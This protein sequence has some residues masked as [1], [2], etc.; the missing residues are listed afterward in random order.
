M[1]YS[2]RMQSRLPARLVDSP[3][4]SPVAGGVMGQFASQLQS[5]DTAILALGSAVRDIDRTYPHDRILVNTTVTP[6]TG[7]AVVDTETGA[8]AT[9]S[10]VVQKDAGG[11]GGAQWELTLSGVVGAMRQGDP[12]TLG[13]FAATA[14]SDLYPVD[15]AWLAG[16]ARIVGERRATTDPDA[17]ARHRVLARAA[18]N[19]SWG[20]I[21]DLLGVAGH[22][23]PS[24]VYLDDGGEFSN[25]DSPWGA[26]P[27]H[28]GQVRVEGT[29]AMSEQTY[30]A[31]AKILRSAAPAGVRVLIGALRTTHH[32]VFRFGTSHFGDGSVLMSLEA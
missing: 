22:M 32:N 21:S 2:A 5:A 30:L 9:I 1:D 23:F 6:S 27:C 20:R 11:G 29:D 31:M 4:L 15:N 13:G 24:G 25:R 10:A 3:A 14:D 28:S 12:L 18:A 8:T 16:C 26:P 17:L 7:Q 19:S